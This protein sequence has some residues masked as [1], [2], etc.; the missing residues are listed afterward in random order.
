MTKSISFTI[1][2]EKFEYSVGGE[3][4]ILIVIKVCNKTARMSR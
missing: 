1:E 2:A 3:K 4:C